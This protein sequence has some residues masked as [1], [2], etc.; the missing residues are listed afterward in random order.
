MG[1]IDIFITSLRLHKSTDYVTNPYRDVRV[2]ANLRLYLEHMVKVRGRRVLLVGEAPGYRGC[3]ITGIPFTSGRVFER[4]K[5]PLLNTL[6]SQLEFSEVVAESSA[7]IVWEYLS[8]K[9]TTPLFWN[10]FPF[11]PHAGRNPHSNRAPT[12]AEIDIGAGYLRELG[13]IFKPEIIAGIGRKGELCAGKVFPDADI[14]YI[15]HPSYGGKR[16]FTAGMNRLLS[17]R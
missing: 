12:A 10:A 15:A 4:I 11:H 17:R 3:R 16:A 9:R 7:T 1:A 13:A 6:G 8:R 5:H 2:A 14:V